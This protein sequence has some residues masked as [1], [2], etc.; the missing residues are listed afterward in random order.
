MR[1]QLRALAAL[2][3]LG[4]WGCSSGGASTNGS[5]G[6]ATG[7]ASSG[8]STTTGSGSTVT[9]SSSTGGTSG[10]SGQSTSGT[11]GTTGTSGT[12][13]TTGSSAT[14]GST[15]TSGAGSSGSTG[16]SGTTGCGPGTCLV[17][18]SCTANSTVDGCGDTCA[19]CA[20]ANASN[21]C[22]AG[23]CTY[24]CSA[25]YCDLGGG[26]CGPNDTIAT[27]GAACGACP[28]DPNG[29]A[30]CM[31]P[32][33]GSPPG[34]SSACALNCNAGYC[35][36]DGGA[37]A[38]TDTGS[39]VNNCGSCGNA[40]S[41]DSTGF[42]TAV[43]DAGTCALDCPSYPDGGATFACEGACNSVATSTDPHN[44][45]QCGNDCGAG[46]C[47]PQGSFYPYYVDGGS[48]GC[49]TPA[50][51]SSVG[52]PH[53]IV[54][55]LNDASFWWV[56]T[57]NG[58]DQ[59]MHWAPGGSG[60]TIQQI[61]NYTT[62]T[63][64]NL[65]VTLANVTAGQEQEVIWLEDT[66]TAT[67]VWGSLGNATPFRLTSIPHSSYTVLG[68]VADHGEAYFGLVPNT[69][70]VTY[71]GSAWL[72]AQNASF[73]VPNTALPTLCNSL[74]FA[75][76]PNSAGQIYCAGTDLNIY[77]STGAIVATYSASTPLL[78]TEGKNLYLLA[79]DSSVS[80]I[81]L[82]ATW[83][84]SPT[85]I[86]T[87]LTNATYLVGFGSASGDHLLVNSGTEIIDIGPSG[88]GTTAYDT[89][90]RSDDFGFAYFPGGSFSFATSS[91]GL[92]GETDH[93]VYLIDTWPSSL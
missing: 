82:S 5:S 25:G 7:G 11:T 24:T 23:Q 38:Q 40:C 9:S 47:A 14:T 87:G 36:A 50:A 52:S 33:P 22:T 56:A 91:L 76:A 29:T 20:V 75:Y 3:V 85:I 90:I 88:T 89:G 48:T 81:D 69:R 57:P 44:C 83:P 61:T 45:H 28:T 6:S 59:V 49:R 37:C 2:C 78:A 43:C 17:Q 53:D 13:A 16:S 34:S 30:A 73:T 72:T 32:A 26:L 18:G 66:G 68:L 93:E 35:P 84:T 54:G 31:P 8:S 1:I 10:L 62:G 4:L 46:W 58:A 60:G 86:R 79:S 67:E 64:S 41:G 80:K 12:T 71:I 77:T 92:I 27:C 63:I 74:A 42:G 70:F 39:D 21:A 15:G 19:V 65:Y 51:I 55:S